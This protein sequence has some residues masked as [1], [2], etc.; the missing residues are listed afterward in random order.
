MSY[1]C[2]IYD[3]VFV[4]CLFGLIPTA[5]FLSAWCI[6]HFVDDETS[7]MVNFW[8]VRIAI[9]VFVLAALGFV[10]IPPKEF[11]CGS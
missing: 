1:I 7:T 5:V 8:I 11:V 2:A 9:C 4:L 6:N 3:R 10:F